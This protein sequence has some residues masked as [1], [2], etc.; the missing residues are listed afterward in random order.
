MKKLYV[1]ISLV[2]L[3]AHAG[4]SQTWEKIYTGYNYILKGIEFPGGQGQVGWAGGQSLTY[5]G[6]GIVIKTTNGGISWTQLW[7]GS[8]QGLEGIS[9]PDM[10]TGYIGG[11]SGY[12]AKTTDGGLTWTPQNPGT[13]IYYYTDVVFKDATHG[14]VTAQTNTGIGVYSTSNGGTTWVTGTGLTGVPY[15][16][17]FV[18]GNTYF[19]VTNGGDIQKSTDGGLSWAT[20]Y[21]A[22]GLL[23]GIDFYNPLIG[24]AAGE[25]GRIIKTYDGGATWQQ[26]VIAFGQPLWHDFAWAS[27]DE[28][29]ACGTPEFVFKSLDGGSTWVDDYPQ[30]TYN[31]AL[32][33][34]M[35]TPDGIGLMCGSQGWFYR[36][37][38]V[39]T[40]A[41][42]AS[43]THVCNGGSVQFTD[44]SIGS[45]TAWNWTFAGG[46][47]AT[48]TLQNPLVTYT[49]P[50]NYD[51]T[52]LV[53]K[54]SITNTLSNPGMIHVEAPV[55]VAP[56]QA[57]GPTAICGSFNYDYLTTAVPAATSY[58]WTADPINAGVFSGTGLTGTLAASNLWNGNFTVKV[59]GVS[60][61]GAGPSS[62]A[63]N[64]VL[65]HQ[66][67]A[68]FLFT[69]GGYC[70]GQAGYEIKL[71]NSDIGVNYQLYKDG[72]A[73][74]P[75][76]PGTGSMLSF[77]FQ[78]AGDYTVSGVNGS[79]SAS[80]Q[81]T[82]SVY[83]I[84]P[85]ATAS[86]PGGAASSC[87]NTPS[88]F[89]AS[90][91]ANALTLVWTLSPPGAGSISQ[92]NSTTATVS[93]NT[94]FSG[95][96]SVS[97]QGQNECGLGTASNALSVTVNPAPAPVA[98][99]IATVCKNQEVTYTTLY[100]AGST[101]AWTVTGGNIVSGQG[102][103]QVSILWVNTGAGSVSVSET[104]ASGCSGL[105]PALAVAVNECT[106]TTEN[107]AEVY[108][109][110]PNPAEDHLDIVF[111]SDMKTPVEV[112]IYNFAGQ[113]VARF[114]EPDIS[115]VHSLKIDI[116]NLNT[117][118]YTL[119]ITGQ[120][121]TL[122]R[123]F[124]RK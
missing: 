113:L 8:Q 112:T 81:G 95:I 1:L 124:I 91:P 55:T 33:E 85:P 2:V 123:L 28:V 69:G 56:S 13:D 78:T 45:P 35:Y 65:T 17:C 29:Y 86:M 41:F 54:G 121:L 50:G 34:I 40:A 72:V 25:D 106:G 62:A 97:V 74:G 82:S 77:G 70:A 108:N 96:V 89:T 58:S 79:C 63:L 46:N 67:N 64:V 66:P 109:V 110:Y 80:M 101:Y 31:P 23:L 84:D 100:N 94:G 37:V 15:K 76:V 71:S 38:P 39:V 20:V 83:L 6:D 103:S 30:S 4:N 47:P 18:S 57:S 36:K 21:A 22:G 104:T 111:N 12:F 27:Q 88:T 118:I 102:S 87:N 10:N 114:P 75:L 26:Q 59:S 68:Y 43:T 60:A 115:N 42:T 24:I 3:L 52:L 32:Y 5:M 116:T 105:S 73:S 122:S 117:G 16:L 120:N 99:G 93:W 9:F 90:L 48:S 49:T 51:V 98:A 11:W 7:T 19:L 14:V 107:N 92:P 119:K 44:Q 53:S 61:C